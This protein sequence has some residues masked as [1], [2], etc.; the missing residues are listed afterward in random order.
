VQ[1]QSVIAFS[2]RFSRAPLKLGE[3]E[4]FAAKRLDI[5]LCKIMVA[6][7]RMPEFAD[8]AAHAEFWK[9]LKMKS[10]DWV[11]V[12]FFFFF[13]ELLFHLQKN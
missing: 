13:F 12:I 11:K 1:K 6:I 9:L 3:G 4:T 5:A 2:L 8:P 10:I 7:A